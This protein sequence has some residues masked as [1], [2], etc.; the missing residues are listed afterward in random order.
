MRKIIHQSFCEL[1][2]LSALTG[3]EVGAR[4]EMKR[5]GASVASRSRRDR[6]KHRAETLVLTV[7]H[8]EPGGLVCDQHDIA[9]CGCSNMGW[10]FAQVLKAPA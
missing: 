2:P 1:A 5:L 6:V 8:R 9:W 10:F 7:Q 4:I 3:L